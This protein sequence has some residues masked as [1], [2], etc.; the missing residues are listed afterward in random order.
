MTR[1][2][3]ASLAQGAYQSISF[4]LAPEIGDENACFTSRRADVGCRPFKFCGHLGNQPDPRTRCS[5]GLCDAPTQTSA[6]SGD[7]DI[8]ARDA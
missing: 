7:E 3:R 6:G 2:L 8:D 4:I 1:N 5:H